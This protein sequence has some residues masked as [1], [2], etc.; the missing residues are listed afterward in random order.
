VEGK[1]GRRRR[2]RVSPELCGC[3]HGDG[4]PARPYRTVAGAVGGGSGGASGEL[5]VLSAGRRKRLEEGGD[6][7]AVGSQMNGLDSL[8][9]GKLNFR[10]LSISKSLIF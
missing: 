2:G 10:P 7:C 3:G 1:G 4:A 6:T 8:P 5:A 9:E